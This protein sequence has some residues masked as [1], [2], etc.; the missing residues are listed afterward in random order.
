MG[1]AFRSNAL[2]AIRDLA[3]KGVGVALLPEWLVMND[4]R[5]RALRVILPGWQSEP[6][7]VNAIHRNKQWGEPR[8]RAFVDHLRAA[9]AA[10]PGA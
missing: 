8:L 1:V 9:Y 3:V 5:R 2:H 6:V 4:V 7:P 10:Y